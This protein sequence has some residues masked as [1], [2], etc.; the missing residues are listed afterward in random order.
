MNGR[1]ELITQAEYAR[2]RNV[3]RAAVT[4]AIKTG[5]ITVFEGGLLDP[6]VADVQWSTNTRARVDSG[7]CAA[8]VDLATTTT[9]EALE[10]LDAAQASMGY[11]N[12]RAMREKAEAEMA[13]RAN[14]KDA[15]L[16]VE[17]EA[18]KRGVFDVVRAARD[19]VMNIGQR[20]A[21]RCIGLSDSREIERIVSE[22][23]RNALEAFEAR[24][25]GLAAIRTKGGN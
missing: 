24:M 23:S 2:R 17:I 6:A 11:V 25:L 14:L 12:Y 7:R 20:A 15:G 13:Q 10:G 3:S 1:V 9:P 21:P 8:G 4:Q 16:L 19:T 5:R 22:E 18:V